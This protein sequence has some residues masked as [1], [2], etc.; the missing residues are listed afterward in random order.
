[1]LPSREQQIADAIA[2]VK[3]KAS[4]SS[5]TANQQ[6]DDAPG[7]GSLVTLKSVSKSA[8]LDDAL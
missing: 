1:M 4:E 6:E 8:S 2:R 5:D 3:G 7:R